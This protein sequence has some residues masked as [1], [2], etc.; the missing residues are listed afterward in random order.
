MKTMV[1]QSGRMIVHVYDICVVLFLL[2]SSFLRH[3]HSVGR[4][5]WV[6]L[7]LMLFALDVLS[8]RTLRV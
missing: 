5:F 6:R 8:E 4:G 3:H 1:R 7:V 2:E